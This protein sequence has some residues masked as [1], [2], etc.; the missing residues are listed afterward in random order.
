MPLIDVLQQ[1]R[2]ES[3]VQGAWAFF[4]N[5]LERLFLQPKLKPQLFIAFMIIIS[6]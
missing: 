3:F 5:H 4:S 6:I 1:S 2:G